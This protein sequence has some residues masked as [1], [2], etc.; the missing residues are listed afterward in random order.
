MAVDTSRNKSDTV[1]RLQQY[2]TT[3]QDTIGLALALRQ[4]AIDKGYQ[5]AGA[6]PSVGSGS[7]SWSIASSKSASSSGPGTHSSRSIRSP[8][9]K[10]RGAGGPSLALTPFGPEFNP[11][12]WARL[13]DER[14]RRRRAPTLGDRADELGA[15]A[16]RPSR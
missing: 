11:L 9:A 13:G 1:S 14:P 5:A 4:E 10:E 15:G 8:T 3:I 7:S 2:C 16:L 12:G 6:D